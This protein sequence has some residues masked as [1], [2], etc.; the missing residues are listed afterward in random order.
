MHVALSWWCQ[1]PPFFLVQTLPP[2]CP[3]AM[4]SLLLAYSSIR[5]PWEAIRK[6]SNFFAIDKAWVRRGYS[7]ELDRH[8]SPWSCYVK[9]P[10]CI[11]IYS[12]SFESFLTP[13][14]KLVLGMYN[15]PMELPDVKRSSPSLP[16][17]QSTLHDGSHHFLLEKSIKIS[18]YCI[19]ILKLGQIVV[20][21]LG[22]FSSFIDL[23]LEKGGNHLQIA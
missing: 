3:S 8:W 20:L 16:P 5:S 12:F 11:S 14:Q 2:I 4:T 15:S 17:P 1:G 18:L 9:G 22:L 21:S 6:F 7:M 13:T 23:P 10:V 19:E